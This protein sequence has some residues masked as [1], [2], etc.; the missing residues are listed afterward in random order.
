MTNPWEFTPEQVDDINSSYVEVMGNPTLNARPATPERELNP[1][2]QPASTKPERGDNSQ[3]VP[4]YHRL[5]ANGE[6]DNNGKSHLYQDH[7]VK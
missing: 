7:Y 6:I 2:Q 5:R 3:W 1:R 4:E